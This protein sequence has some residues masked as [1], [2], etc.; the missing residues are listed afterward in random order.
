MSLLGEYCMA[1]LCAGEHGFKAGVELLP[2]GITGLAAGQRIK[3]ALLNAVNQLA[4][5]PLGGDVVV[6]AARDVG[7]RVEA[8]DVGGDGVAMMVIVKQ[9]AVEVGLAEGGL[10]GFEVHTGHDSA[11]V[12][13]ECNP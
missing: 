4:R 11:C 12:V 3:P 1:R 5:L 7:L 10:N 13:G 8:Q 2:T 6:P 9:P